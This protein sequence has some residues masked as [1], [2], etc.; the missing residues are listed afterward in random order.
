MKFHCPNC[1]APFDSLGLPVTEVTCPNCKT[2]FQAEPTLNEK[3]SPYSETIEM[4]AAAY[5]DNIVESISSLSDSVKQ[6]I[7]YHLEDV[8]L[9]AL[10]QLCSI[11][12]GAM[13][14]N[15]KC[16]VCSEIEAQSSFDLFLH[17]RWRNTTTAIHLCKKHLSN[18][19]IAI[20]FDLNKNNLDMKI[21]PNSW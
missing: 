20:D 7:L 10:G 3:R 17:N 11:K 6:C 21:E 15:A 9:P 8:I 12:I 1:N 16:S 4:E 19:C 18:V 13:T 5:I 14:T 2:R